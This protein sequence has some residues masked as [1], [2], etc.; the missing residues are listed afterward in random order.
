MRAAEGLMGGQVA[1]LEV[2]DE[3][4]AETLWCHEELWRMSEKPSPR[5]SHGWRQCPRV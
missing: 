3:K 5:A 2:P 1:A 4:D